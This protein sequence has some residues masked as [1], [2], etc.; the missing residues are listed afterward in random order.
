MSNETCNICE[1]CKCCNGWEF[2]NCTD[3]KYAECDICEENNDGVNICD[4]CSIC[5]HK[6]KCDVLANC[7]CDC[8]S[9]S[10]DEYYEGTT[11]ED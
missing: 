11:S 5:V 9:F 4:N 2:G 10:E 6:C 1:I 7:K 8:H 3:C